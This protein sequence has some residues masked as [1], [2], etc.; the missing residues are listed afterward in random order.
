MTEIWQNRNWTKSETLF[1]IRHFQTKFTFFNKFYPRLSIFETKKAWIYLK[2]LIFGLNCLFRNWSFL[3]PK[4]YIPLKIGHFSEKWFG[5]YN[6]DRTIFYVRIT[7]SKSYSMIL[8]LRYNHGW[9][10]RQSI[11]TTYCLRMFFTSA[12][13]RFSS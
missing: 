7:W 5:S 4:N 6:L 1:E 12:Q 2:T 9:W 8:V 3:A 10:W 11:F 13:K